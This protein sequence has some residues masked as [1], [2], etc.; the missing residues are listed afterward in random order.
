MSIRTRSLYPT[1]WHYLVIR[2]ATPTNFI[3]LYF[4]KNRDDISFMP[5][6][7]PFTVDVY[8]NNTNVTIRKMIGDSLLYNTNF[9]AK[10]D[11]FICYS[12]K[13][14]DIIFQDIDSNCVHCLENIQQLHCGRS[15]HAPYCAASKQKKRRKRK[16]PASH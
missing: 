1:V 15:V 4:S 11:L 14:L 13:K 8:G 6:A 16:L 9:I 3:L 12:Q 10:I 5:V 7:G 2:S